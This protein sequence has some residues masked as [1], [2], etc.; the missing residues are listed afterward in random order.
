MSENERVFDSFAAR[1]DDIMKRGLG[2]FGGDVDYYAE[3]KVRLLKKR[4][5]APV[6]EILE[7][8]CGVGR[9]LH[10]L[11]RHFPNSRL[12]GCDVSPESLRA[13]KDR[14]PEATFFLCD[15][16]SVRAHRSRFDLILVAGVLHHV[17]SDA[18]KRTAFEMLR[19]LLNDSGTLCVFDHNPY[20]PIVVN[21]LRRIPWDA[22]AVL[23]T[24]KMVCRLLTEAGFRVR[25]KQYVLFFPSALKRLSFL[26]P[27]LCR[28]PVGAQYFIKAT[29]AA[30]P[31]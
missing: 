12:Y 1:Y 5:P 22:T 26:D 4:I 31:F 7:F 3:Y 2:R 18:E 20:N 15:A 23:L 30:P 17:T 19:E 16:E 8:G 9:N 10:H 6:S 28:F 11:R 29:T 13:A 27:L 24:R 25:E 21:S 14:C